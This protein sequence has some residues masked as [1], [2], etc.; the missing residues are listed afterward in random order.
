MKTLALLAAILV[1]AVSSPADTS[2]Q[3]KT[4]PHVPTT[5][6]ITWEAPTNNLPKSLWIYKRLGPQTFTEPVISNAMVL[7]SLQNERIPKPSTKNFFAWQKEGPDYSGP[8]PCVFSI[9]PFDAAMSYWMP[10]Y[11][12]P[13]GKD[14]PSDEEIVASARKYASQLG[15]DPAQMLQRGLYARVNNTDQKGAGASKEVCGRGV[16]LAR[17]LDGVAFFSDNNAGEGTEG[18]AVEFGGHGQIRSF[19]LIWPKLERYESH[20]TASPQ[21]IIAFIRARKIM[22]IRDANYERF[23]DKVRALSGASKIV[24]TKITPCYTEG[25]YWEER[26][27]NQLSKFIN[28]IA[29]LEAVAKLENKDIHFRFLAPVLEVDVVGAVESDVKLSPTGR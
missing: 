27:N 18:F 19:C 25:V 16:F 17:Q 20:E 5:T 15:L 3:E 2:S 1:M 10:N 13:S 4:S 23:S 12:E 6:P 22:V 21:Q 26:K 11:D 7:A 28:P 29:E 9:T 8:I 14:F 24:I